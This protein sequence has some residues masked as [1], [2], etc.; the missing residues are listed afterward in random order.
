MEKVKKKIWEL[1][2]GKQNSV[3]SIYSNGVKI[4][5]TYSDINDKEEKDL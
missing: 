3:I 1:R 2:Y 5:L 4:R